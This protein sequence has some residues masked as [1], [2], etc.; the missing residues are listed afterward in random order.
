[1]GQ[2]HRILAIPELPPAWSDDPPAFV[3]YV[4]NV[5][6]TAAIPTVLGPVAAMPDAIKLSIYAKIIKKQD[7]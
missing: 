4:I 5:G 2:M 6:G 3:E 7:S 1:M